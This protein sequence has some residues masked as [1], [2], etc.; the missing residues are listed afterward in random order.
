MIYYVEDETNIRELA[1]YALKQAGLETKGFP[2]AEPFFEACHEKVPDLILLDIMLPRID[3]LTILR[4]LREEPRTADVPI[5]MLTAKGSEIDKVTGLDAGA[6]DYLPKPFGMMELISRCNA[7]LRRSHRTTQKSTDR[8]TC[9]PISIDLSA[10]EAYAGGVKLELTLKEFGL[11]RKLMEDQG[12][13][14]SR[15]QL[16]RDVWDTDFMGETRTVDT[17][18]LTLRKK[19]NDAC[20]GA[21]E[22]IQTVRGVGYRMHPDTQGN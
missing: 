22:Y 3:G 5:M 14:F 6:D 17:H 4:R 8:I 16:L 21:G 19:L 7:L 13:A 20:D 1:I 9:G 2:S 15:S 11:L 10:H 18:V 12:R